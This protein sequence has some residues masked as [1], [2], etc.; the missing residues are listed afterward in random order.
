MLLIGSRGSALA[1]AQTSWVKEQILRRFPDVELAIKVI[2][3]SADRDA[4]TSIRFG[5]AIGVFVKELEQALMDEQ[6]DLAVHSMKDLPTRIP[7]GLTIGA[8]P[9]REDARDA[10]VTATGEGLSQLPEGSRI[11]TGSVRRQ[12]QILARRP[13]LK[14]MEIR[15]NI[16]TRLKKLQDGLYD[17]LVLACAGLNRLGLQ[18]RIFAPLSLLEMLPAPG[19]GALAIETR[20]GDRRLEPIAA[21]LDHPATSVAVT[22]ERTFL[23]RMG[24][25]CNVPV[26]A[27]AR[28]AGNF[29]EME[30]LV[31][32]PDGGRVVR[33]S[34][35]GSADAAQEAAITLADE[36]L[37]R[38]GRAILDALRPNP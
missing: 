26:A 22:A 13:D 34:V 23:Q 3:T 5:P 4:T 10:L 1:L 37:A 29:I 27:Y 35:R 25:G 31:A 19:Q 21:A 33:E 30:G 28:L 17:A 18:N 8:I 11:G 9:E 24:G 38:G 7:A 15:G 12:A 32:S 6:I 20:A 14:I 36:I 16:D 2:K